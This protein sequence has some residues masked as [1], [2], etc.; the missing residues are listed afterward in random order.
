MFRVILL[1]TAAVML[2]SLIG[3]MIAGLRGGISSALG[4]A[5]YVLPNLFLALYLKSAARRSGA[6]FVFG[7]MFGEAVKLALVL[8]LLF[9][10][11]REYGD[12]HMPSLLVGLVLATQALFFLG[13]WKKS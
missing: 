7:F 8:G 9:I 12:V 10:A 11:V 4:G 13:F 2:A 5:V 1:Q 6:G 3:G